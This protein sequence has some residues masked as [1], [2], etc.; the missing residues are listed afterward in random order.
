MVEGL[1]HLKEKRRRRLCQ[2]KDRKKVEYRKH[3][4]NKRVVWNGESQD[5]GPHRPEINRF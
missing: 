3:G 5:P 2:K 1:D 4:K